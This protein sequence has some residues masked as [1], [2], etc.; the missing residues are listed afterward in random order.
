M[1]FLRLAGC[2]VAALL[3]LRVEAAPPLQ[4]LAVASPADTVYHSPTLTVTELA[5][6]VYV[7]ISFL[8]FGK[9]R[10]PCNGL[11]V[12]DGGAS[13][14]VDSPPTEAAAAELVAV[15]AQQLAAPLA[16]LVVN[17]FHDDCLGGLAALHRLGIPTYASARTH[18]L[19]AADTNVAELPRVTFRDSLRLRVGAREVL[20]VYPG[21]GHTHDNTVSYV[22]DA[23]V[24][25]G[26]CLV[27]A[28]GGTRGNLADA[29]TARWSDT[30]RE[31]ARR[32]PAARIVVPGHGSP[33]GRELLDY[34]AELFAGDAPV[35][36]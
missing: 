3:S 27:K 23:G 15:A 22:P 9:M 34:T 29:D 8:A 2:S 25:F 31:V 33:G 4:R 36:G 35:G 17:H 28:A 13:L 19:A 1:R 26:G 16:G 30:A 12:V 10:V 14:A 6:G 18:A 5:E 24:L 21:P 20:T 32:F 7:H 11:L